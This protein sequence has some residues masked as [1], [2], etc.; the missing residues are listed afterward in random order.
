MSDEGADGSRLRA[1][2]LRIDRDPTQARYINSIVAKVN[3][4]ALEIIKEAA[5][6]LIVIGKHMKNLIEDVQKKHPEL[7]V[8]WRELNLASKE[9]LAQRMVADFKRINYF[10]QLMHLCT[11]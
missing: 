2:I 4:N 11:Q 8:N 3:N 10:I 7:L 6:D 1:A 5:Q 9:P